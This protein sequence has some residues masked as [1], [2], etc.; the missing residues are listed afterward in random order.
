MGYMKQ[1]KNS[2]SFEEKLL[3]VAELLDEIEK[4]DEIDTLSIHFY[5]THLLIA[6]WDY[7]CDEN[8]S[9][10]ER[11]NKTQLKA[12]VEFETVIYSTIGHNP[13]VIRKKKII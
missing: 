13:K 9:D 8:S 3:T 5:I 1:L 12:N 6:V 4:L 11:L 7:W 2:F 10:S